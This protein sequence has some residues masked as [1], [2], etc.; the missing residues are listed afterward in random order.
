MRGHTANCLAM[1]NASFTEA[2]AG[3]FVAVS[4][5]ELERMA[6]DDGSRTEIHDGTD[7]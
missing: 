1:L 4:I 6:E 5:D 2:E 3:K 7:S